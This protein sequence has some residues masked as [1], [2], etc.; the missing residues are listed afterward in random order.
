M[1]GTKNSLLQL[2]KCHHHRQFL[3]DQISL[4]VW[5]HKMQCLASESL[6]LDKGNLIRLHYISQHWEG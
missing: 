6:I 2:T 5:S 4:N 3:I 1:D